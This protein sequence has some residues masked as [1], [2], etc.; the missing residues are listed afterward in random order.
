M[1]VADFVCFRSNSIFQTKELHLWKI[2]SL[3]EK[4]QSGSINFPRN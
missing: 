1:V 3:E 2:T 4:R